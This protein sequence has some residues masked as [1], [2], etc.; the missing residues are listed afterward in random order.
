MHLKPPFFRA[1]HYG[2]RGLVLSIGSR[3]K[4]VMHGESVTS[5]TKVLPVEKRGK[6]RMINLWWYSAARENGVARCR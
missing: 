3:D 1:N 4:F 2:R 5:C 6:T